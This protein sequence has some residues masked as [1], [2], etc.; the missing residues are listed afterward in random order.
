MHR[1]RLSVCP[2]GP[3]GV[4]MSTVMLDF[5]P[6]W[7]CLMAGLWL[8]VSVWGIVSA[9]WLHSIH[10]ISWITNSWIMITFV[11]LRMFV[12]LSD[13]R[14]RMGVKG[15]RTMW[16]IYILHILST[17]KIMCSR[18][19]G[20]SA[21]KEEGT[22]IV[23]IVHLWSSITSPHLRVKPL[24]LPLSRWYAWVSSRKY[25]TFH[26]K[27]AVTGHPLPYSWR[28]VSPEGSMRTWA[29]F[30]APSRE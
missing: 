19:W 6:P 28:R 22:W 17:H 10:L 8:S 18:Q 1:T 26:T 2:R 23:R 3:K 9:Q 27:S 13:Y 25:M 29:L 15:L 14:E 30:L 12:R 24:P 7:T 21:L 20:D 11:R 16:H 5:R 4:N